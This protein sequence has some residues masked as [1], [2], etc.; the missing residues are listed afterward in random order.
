MADDTTSKLLLALVVFCIVLA[1]GL[2]ILSP[3]P[4]TNLQT[5]FLDALLITLSA[6]VTTL[7]AR[8]KRPPNRRQQ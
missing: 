6:A 4:P 5:R 1:G 7:L 8:L 3:D 2:A